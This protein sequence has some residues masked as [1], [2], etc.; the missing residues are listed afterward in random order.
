MM[1]QLLGYFY[2]IPIGLV[3]ALLLWVIRE[4]H[5]SAHRKPMSW[6]DAEKR[7]KQRDDELGQGV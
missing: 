2:S 6:G 5:D 3:F 4:R 7:V 1:S